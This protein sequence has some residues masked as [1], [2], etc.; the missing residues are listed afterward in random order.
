MPST[1]QIIEHC[2]NNH[3]L[4]LEQLEFFSALVWKSGE[5]KT[6][7][8]LK[9]SERINKVVEYMTERFGV[10]NDQVPIHNA[11]TAR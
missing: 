4:L 10:P 3:F 8:I 11:N 1:N 6:T 9:A 5:G 2:S 7:Y